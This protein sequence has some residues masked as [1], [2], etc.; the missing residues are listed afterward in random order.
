MRFDLLFTLFFMAASCGRQPV[1]K[2]G[3]ADNGSTVELKSGETLEV[4]LSQCQGCEQT[5]KIPGWGSCLVMTKDEFV[6]NCKDC[7]GG[8]GMR[9]FWFEA[10]KAG[11]AQLTFSYFGDTVNYT[12][13]I[14]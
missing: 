2:V 11:R 14:H 12:I 6:P 3:K 1:Q 10:H 5:W 13:N 8:N 7:N 9:T 4:D